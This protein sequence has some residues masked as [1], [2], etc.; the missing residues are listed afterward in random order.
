[1]GAH[2]PS[3]LT[4]AA[5][6]KPLHSCTHAL[7]EVPPSGASPAVP[8]EIAQRTIAPEIAQRTMEECL[9]TA[10]DLEEGGELAEGST[11]A[12]CGGLHV[13]LPRLH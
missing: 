8:P 7:S 1:M 12:E 2:S 6:Y 9:L 5:S 3:C 11:H 4:E 10:E 13:P